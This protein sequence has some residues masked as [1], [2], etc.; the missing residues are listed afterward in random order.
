MV[1]LQGTRQQNKGSGTT[2]SKNVRRDRIISQARTASVTSSS[3]LQLLLRVI[4]PNL[5]ELGLVVALIGVVQM[6]ALIP[7]H[8]QSRLVWYRRLWS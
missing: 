8:W 1:V 2:R 5:R 7:H 4:L 6:S 3:M